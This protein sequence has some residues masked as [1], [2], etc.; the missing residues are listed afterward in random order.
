MCKKTSLVLV[1]FTCFL[2][3]GASWQVVPA[4]LERQI[5]RAADI[6]DIVRGCRKACQ[7][8]TGDIEVTLRQEHQSWRVAELN[9]LFL[10]SVNDSMLEPIGNFKTIESLKLD[11]Q[12][13]PLENQRLTTSALKAF[14]NLPNLRKLTV[15]WAWIEANPQPVFA[16]S[17]LKYLDL[18][19]NR[20]TTVTTTTALDQLKDLRNLRGLTLP[21]C[22]LTDDD[23]KY[24]KPLRQLEVLGVGENITDAGLEDLKELENLR[25][26]R[27]A[28][29]GARGLLSLKNLPHL[30]RLEVEKYGPSSRDSELSVL[31]GVKWLSIKSIDGNQAESIRLPPNLETLEVAHE[32]VQHLDMLSTRH[33]RNVRVLLGPAMDRRKNGV[34]S[35]DLS[36]LTSL[37]DLTGVELDCPFEEDVKEVARLGSLRS[38]SLQG[39]CASRIGD[40]GI[41]HWRPCGN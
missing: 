23:M 33:I 34:Q 37:K 10:D 3:I 22:G 31:T 26:L 16:L 35:I 9:C 15:P 24:L 17:Q 5:D 38:L 29:L 4:E 14:A 1:P 12:F 13:F 28:V 30:E 20:D 21:C 11:L 7:N 2:V 39:T 25:S 41:A 8:I 32:V 19:S 18:Q 27:I 40:G 36:W 6:G